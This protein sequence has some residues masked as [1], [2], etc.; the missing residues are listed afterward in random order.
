MERNH[1]ET[2]DACPGGSCLVNGAPLGGMWFGPRLGRR[3]RSEGP[4]K[5]YKKVED[6]P[7]E[8][9]IAP[10]SWNLLE[11]PGKRPPLLLLL[12]SSVRKLRPT[13]QGFHGNCE[14]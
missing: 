14:M 6:V 11:E 10:G 13:N 9:V 5:G 1:P 2:S 3:R 12:L 8:R 7:P 4:S